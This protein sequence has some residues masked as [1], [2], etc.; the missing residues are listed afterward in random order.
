VIR[1][2]IRALALLTAVLIVT[3]GLGS[4]SALTL[5]PL[6]LPALTDGAADIFVARVERTASGYDDHGL[7]AVWTTFAIAERLKGGPNTTVTLKQLGSAFADRTIVPHAALPRFQPGETV[8]LFVH[9][10]SALGFTSPV[11]LAQGCFRVHEQNGERLAENDVG[12]RNLAAPPATTR[13]LGPAATAS[14]PGAVPLETL[15][16]RVRALVEPAP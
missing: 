12:N 6:D 16:A 11:G 8:L 10:E 5:L 4:A 9:G 14:T 7:P 3:I 1:R 13:A 2:R 15:L